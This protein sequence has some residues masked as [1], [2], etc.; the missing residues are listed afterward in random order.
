MCCGVKDHVSHTLVYTTGLW[1]NV[2]LG[3]QAVVLL[4]C[5]TC[6]GNIFP[7]AVTVNVV[8]ICLLSSIYQLLALAWN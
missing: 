5:I 1:G 7:V 6:A 4:P 8:V 2:V 3:K